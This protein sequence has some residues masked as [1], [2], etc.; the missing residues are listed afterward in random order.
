M[1]CYRFA[2]LALTAVVSVNLYASNCDFLRNTAMTFFT[3]EDLQLSKAAQVKA[4]NHFKDGQAVAWKN[5]KTG[6]HGIFSPLRTVNVNG[7]VCRD[8]KMVNSSHLVHEK[9]T[10]RFCKMH[11]VWK[12]V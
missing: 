1:K 8:L 7:D 6:S 2:A 11:D 9:A 12:I 4:L 10:Y 3:K 5:P